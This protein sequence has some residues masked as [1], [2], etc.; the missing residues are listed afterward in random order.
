MTKATPASITLP[1]LGEMSSGRPVLKST[2]QTLIGAQ[3]YAYGRQGINV[4]NLVFDPGWE[5]LDFASGG[6]AYHAVGDTATTPGI[7]Q[8]DQHTAIFQFQRLRYN[9]VAADQGYMLDLY[10]YARNLDIRVTCQRLDTEDGN[11]GSST[12]VHTLTTSHS[13]TDSEWQLDTQEFTKAEASRSGTY[14]DVNSLAYFLVYVEAKV[15]ASGKG[16]LHH[17]AVRE[18]PITAGTN[19]PR[20]A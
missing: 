20:G 11:T 10:A 18:S 17:L 4:M 16:Y 6:N 5:S 14:V 2:W 19:L 1:A 15:P 7:I 9:S 13:S 12:N 3:H 8:L